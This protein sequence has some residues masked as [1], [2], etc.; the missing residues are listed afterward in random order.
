MGEGGAPVFIV[1]KTVADC[2]VRQPALE[3]DVAR[4]VARQHG[5]PAASLP[6]VGQ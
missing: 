3:P 6:V 4:A 2:L 5:K 1:H